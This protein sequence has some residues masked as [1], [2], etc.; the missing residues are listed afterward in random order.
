MQGLPLRTLA[1]VKPMTTPEADRQRLERYDAATDEYLLAIITDEDHASQ[2]ELD[3]GQ[4]AWRST[5]RHDRLHRFVDDSGHARYRFEDIPADQGG[6]FQLISLIAEGGRGAEFSEL[7]MFG[8]RLLT[9]DD[10]TGLVCEIR[11][12]NQL[13]PR[14]ILMTGSGDERFKGFKS[15]WATLCGDQLIVGSHGK[16]PEEEWIKVVDRNYGLQSIDWSDRY[17]L[18][19]EALAVGEHGYV[20]HEA[21]EWHPY[22]RQWLFFPRKVSTTPFDESIDS[23]ERG[24][25]KL[26]IASEDFS[27]IQV[28]EVGHCVPER[29]ISSFKLVPGRPDECIGLKSVEIG[30]RTESYLFCFNLDGEILT[31][32]LFIGDYKCEGVEFL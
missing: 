1:T 6:E 2:V 17:A 30:D 21:A 29:G 27:D 16:R 12:Q 4:I 32:D 24:C 31:D 7:V 14:Q 10:R 13:V 8:K 5:L 25:N 26:V 18:I 11:G 9:F 20:I 23:R 22:R 19:R 28:I 15:E 3:D